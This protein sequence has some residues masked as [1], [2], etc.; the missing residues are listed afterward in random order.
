ME[1]IERE[2][3]GENL[4]CSFE[5]EIVHAA[6]K[7]LNSSSHQLNAVFEDQI[8]SGQGGHQGDDEKIIKR[9]GLRNKILK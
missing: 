7:H 6:K 2:G 8:P 1:D 3:K 5:F 9:D 4:D